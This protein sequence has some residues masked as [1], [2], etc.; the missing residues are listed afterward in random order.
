MATA[1]GCNERHMVSM[2][3]DCCGL[4]LQ[5]MHATEVS[6]S[7]WLVQ[8]RDV[9]APGEY[10]AL[11]VPFVHLHYMARSSGSQQRQ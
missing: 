9:A 3:L 10:L 5:V 4:F 11:D 7:Q 8:L 2:N 1:H 6:G